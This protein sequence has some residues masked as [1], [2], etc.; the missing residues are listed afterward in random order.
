MTCKRATSKRSG[1]KI[2][3]NQQRPRPQPIST[4]AGSLAPAPPHCASAWRSA[5]LACGKHRRI[6]TSLEGLL[7]GQVSSCTQGHPAIKILI[8]IIVVFRLGASR[9]WVGLPLFCSCIP[10]PSPTVCFQ[11]FNWGPNPS[12][13]QTSVAALTLTLALRRLF[14][15]NLRTR[16]APQIQLSSPVLFMLDSCA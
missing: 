5:T 16:P 3:Q 12:T 6:P 8:Q 13:Q 2:T 4:R 11:R 14:Y 7:R 10:R 1:P 15:K 9:Y